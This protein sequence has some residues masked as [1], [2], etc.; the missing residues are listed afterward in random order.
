MGTFETTRRGQESVVPQRPRYERAL[1]ALDH[2]GR[3]ITAR[4]SAWRPRLLALEV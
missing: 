1:N 4:P 3:L 2:P